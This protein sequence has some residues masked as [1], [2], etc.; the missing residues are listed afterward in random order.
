M[1][2][3]DSVFLF[4]FKSISNPCGRGS[5]FRGRYINRCGTHIFLFPLLWPKQFQGS[6]FLPNH[7]ERRLGCLLK[8]DMLLIQCIFN[9]NFVFILNVFLTKHLSVCEYVVERLN[10]LLRVYTCTILGII[11]WEIC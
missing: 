7:P 6:Y 4:I 3:L 11:S 5:G 2:D 8:R 10:T 1:V 9:T